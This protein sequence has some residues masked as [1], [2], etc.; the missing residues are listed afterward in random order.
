MRNLPH[1]RKKPMK[2][3]D[4]KQLLAYRLLEGERAERLERAGAS[5]RYSVLPC[6]GQKAGAVFFLHGVASN[7]SRWEEFIEH[8]ALRD[9]F[10]IIRCDLRGHAASVCRG[11]AR[12]EDWCADT[13]A[14]LDA[15]GI[16]KAV[17]VG[18]SLGA[19]V[20]VNFS[21][22]YTERVRGCALLD[23]L[24]S[25]A[26]TPKALAMRAKL[27]YIKAMEGFF[28]CTG[29]LG[30]HRRL[31]NQDLRAMDANARRKIAAGGE[32]LE[33]FIREYSSAKADLQYIHSAVYLRDLVEVGRPTP[34]P[35]KIKAPM[36]VIGASAGTFTNPEAMQA[37]VG[38]LA[39]GTWAQVQCAHWPM[40]ECPQDVAAVIEKWVF[41]RF[42]PAS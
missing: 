30:F 17:I 7:G 11:R 12:I 32:E 15:E 4:E 34:A 39:D 38:K 27:P 18:H 8:T 1:S 21:A 36:L 24:L 9:R 29:A 35:E 13:A 25:E 42:A 26:L 16:D 19:Q 10:D 20:A 14:V 33:E 41:A 22:R 6:R 37:W 5:L 40:T 23:P 3:D 2:T 28:R 31:K